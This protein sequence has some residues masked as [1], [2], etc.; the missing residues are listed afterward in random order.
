MVLA[1]MQASAIANSRFIFM[2]F[3]FNDSELNLM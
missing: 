3:W 2:V 1:P